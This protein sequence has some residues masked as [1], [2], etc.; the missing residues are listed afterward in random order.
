M[1]KK[2]KLTHGQLRRV[3][4]NQKKHIDGHKK[5]INWD[6][7]LLEP[8]REGIVISRF[9][10]HA[11][12]EDMSSHQVHRCNLRRSIESLVTGDKVIWR[13]GREQLQGIAGVVEAVHERRSVLTRPDY[14]DGV[15]PI[16]AN[17]DQVII[18][19]AILPELSTQIIDRYLIATENAKFDPLILINKI[20]LIDAK[21]KQ[22]V[23]EISAQYRAIGYTLL[24]ASQQ[25]GEGMDVLKAHLA[26]KTNIFV[27][28]SGVG[29][30]SLVNGLLPDVQAQ[31]GDISENS[32]LG[33]H[34][35]TT[36]RLYHF[37]DGGD[38]IDSPG[39][40]EF[41]LWHLDTEQITQGFV[42]FQPY[43]GGCKFRDC[44]HADDP[45]CLI[46]QAVE[47]G[48]IS[49]S[50]FESYHKIIESMSEMKANRQFSRNKE[51]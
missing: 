20:D 40:R 46:R 38:L 37:A 49:R 41:G 27:G 2:K 33:Q 35:T 50:R 4:T 39:V 44:K 14:Y 26:N 51:K 11:D 13:P 25:T 22:A 23:D 31:I 48:K 15:K 10:Q 3:R 18:V 47:E 9:G 12:I 5:E 29:K 36:A 42:E 7:S 34:T 19:S 45:D 28:Q 43:L 24:Q 1:A 30:S 21:S 6:E 8:P 32:G 16:A 17:I